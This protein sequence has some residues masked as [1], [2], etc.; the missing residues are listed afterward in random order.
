[1]RHDL[2]I[3]CS[4]LC[5]RILPKNITPG[6]IQDYLKREILQPYPDKVSKRSRSGGQIPTSIQKWLK[7]HKV[8]DTNSVRLGI[9]LHELIVSQHQQIW[10]TR[11]NEM[12]IRHLLFKDRLRLFS[13]PKPLNKM[14]EDDYIAYAENL[15]RHLK[16]LKT[17]AD[18]ETDTNDGKEGYKQAHHA[19]SL[20]ACS[21]DPTQKRN[22]EDPP[23]NAP[24][25][26]RY[27]RAFPENVSATRKR[28][29]DFKAN[30]AATPT[31]KA[32]SAKG[33]SGPHAEAFP[34]Q[35]SLFQNFLYKPKTRGDGDCL[36]RA[37]LKA[38]GD[39]KTHHMALR[40]HCANYVSSNWSSL[41]VEANLM[42]QFS[43]Q[44]PETVRSSYHP[45]PTA[46]EY[47]DFM[48]VNGHWGSNLEARAAAII[49][50]RPILIWTQETGRHGFLMNFATNTSHK[51][52]IHLLHSRIHF[53]ALLPLDPTGNTSKTQD[54]ARK[55]GLTAISIGS[56]PDMRRN[57]PPAPPATESPKDAK[58]AI[59]TRTLLDFCK[60]HIK[61]KPPTPSINHT[62]KIPTDPTNK[63]DPLK[64]SKTS[65]QPAPQLSKA[66]ERQEAQLKQEHCLSLSIKSRKEQCSI[67]PLLRTD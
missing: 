22:R 32:A 47:D 11:C 31:K 37:I 25:S 50:E 56:T 53:D 13:N 21:Q 61:A 55:V 5:Q 30:E 57:K 7:N 44:L 6:E 34:V 1:M 10:H 36:F 12:K 64:D 33:Q 60:N 58:Y 49:L 54:L 40:H 66:L 14:T 42:H 17:E 3:E 4:D 29:L 19:H 26:K 65:P 2:L 59:K 16:S 41:A 24:T 39:P 8:N 43:P 35:E 9:K 52:T 28:K 62:I 51:G 27:K 48:K 20:P 46:K 18:K 67:N 23:N 45:F 63:T 38:V 15:S